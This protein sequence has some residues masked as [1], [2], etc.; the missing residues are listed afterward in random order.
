MVT[1]V[2]QLPYS[3]PLWWLKNSRCS[4]QY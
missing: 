4:I 1:V 3:Y 2:L